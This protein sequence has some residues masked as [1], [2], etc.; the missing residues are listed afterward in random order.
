MRQ[1]ALLAQSRRATHALPRLRRSRFVGPCLEDRAV[2]RDSALSTPRFAP[3]R[4]EFVVTSPAR[5]VACPRCASAAAPWR[6]NSR[7][8]RLRAGHASGIGRRTAIHIV[9]VRARRASCLPPRNGG[10]PMITSAVGPLGLGAVRVQQRIPA[11]DGVER[12]RIGLRATSKPLRA[13]PLDLADPDRHA[14][15]LGGVGVDLDALHCSGPTCGNSRGR[16]SASA[17]R[18]A[19]CSRSFSA[20]R[21]I[22]E[23]AGAAGR[24]EHAEARAGGR[25]RPR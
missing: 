4:M 11:L 12:A 16:P 3:P 20:Q 25:G 14:R 17:S 21:E 10:L 9:V 7:R 5:A 19:R 13:H 18:L 6:T 8:G 15:Q 23:V 22:E 24:V 2:W 1:L